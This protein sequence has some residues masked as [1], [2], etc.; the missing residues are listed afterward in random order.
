[1]LKQPIPFID[2]TVPVLAAQVFRLLMVYRCMLRGRRR[3]SS[4]EDMY[5][6][7]VLVC[8]DKIV[9]PDLL[10]TTRTRAV[11]SKIA[12]YNIKEMDAIFRTNLSNYERSAILDVKKIA[13]YDFSQ[14]TPLPKCS[15]LIRCQAHQKIHLQI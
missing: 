4:F 15:H 9:F 3:L 5:A 13:S 2:V 7:F 1:M 6:S 10:L 11:T 12:F 14:V 8:S